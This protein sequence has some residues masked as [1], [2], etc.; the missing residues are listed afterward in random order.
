MWLVYT[1]VSGL[2]SGTFSITPIRLG[3]DQLGPVL[4]D[5]VGHFAALTVVL[6]AGVCWLWW[7]LVIALVIAT[8]WLVPRASA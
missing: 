8:L 6:P 2:G 5:A 4:R 7:L 1:R 3:I